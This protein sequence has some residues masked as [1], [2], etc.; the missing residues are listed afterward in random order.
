MVVVAFV[1]ES[2]VVGLVW[3]LVEKVIKYQVS[4]VGRHL[5]PKLLIGAWL[6]MIGSCE[7]AVPMMGNRF[8]SI[9]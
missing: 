3:A 6:S 7:C 5:F 8:D 9:E 1:T 4:T 2:E